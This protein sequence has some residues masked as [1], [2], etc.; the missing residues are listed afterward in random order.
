MPTAVAVRFLP[1]PARRL[2]CHHSP[3]DSVSVP[4]DIP[5]LVSAHTPPPQQSTLG[6]LGRTGGGPSSPP[7]F[8]H[9]ESSHL[10]ARPILPGSLT[11]QIHPE[12]RPAPPSKLDLG[13]DRPL[14]P[15][16]TQPCSRLVRA[17][18]LHLNDPT[19]CPPVPSPSATWQS[20]QVRSHP[21]LCKT[22]R[23]S[24]GPSDKKP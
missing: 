16:P 3:W 9:P 22:P 5:S 20:T 18:P 17:T 1:S 14:L 21:S 4:L 19:F 13:W 15:S 23:G 12:T 8:S 11:E 6:P 24:Q 10:R 7:A 2:L